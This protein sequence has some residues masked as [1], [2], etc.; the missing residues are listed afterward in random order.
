MN[1]VKLKGGECVPT[2]THT[3]RGGGGGVSNSA[4][5]PLYEIIW[6]K[7]YLINYIVLYNVI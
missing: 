6:Y 7:T 2:H 3:E 4:T 1:L 5:R